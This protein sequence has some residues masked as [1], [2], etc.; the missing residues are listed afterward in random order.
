MEGE[1]AAPSTPVSGANGGSLTETGAGTTTGS[2][3][4][5]VGVSKPADLS[6]NTFS[7]LFAA[8]NSSKS[9]DKKVEEFRTVMKTQ[10]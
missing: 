4:S 8:I 3:L 10:R 5:K 7:L 1:L 2:G 6:N 9:F